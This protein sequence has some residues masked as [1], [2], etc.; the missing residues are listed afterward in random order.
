MTT[1]KKV[2]VIKQIT[3]AT[4]VVSI[5]LAAISLFMTNRAIRTSY[6][7]DADKTSQQLLLHWYDMKQSEQQHGDLSVKEPMKTEIDAYKTLFIAESIFLMMKS[8]DRPQAW[9]GTV[10]FL[11]RDATGLTMQD[12]V[13]DETYNAEFA[14]RV[15]RIFADGKNNKGESAEKF[16]DKAKT[17]SR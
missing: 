2:R 10:D 6:T 14:K 3:Q 9:L 11:I 17:A 1:N 12:N 8:S 13:I 7:I 5:A 15:K 16:P 4:G